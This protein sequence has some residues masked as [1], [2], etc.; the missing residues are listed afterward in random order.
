MSVVVK[1]DIRATVETAQVNIHAMTK[2]SD[3]FLVN[4]SL[5]RTIVV[6]LCMG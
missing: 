6:R 3:A 5:V 4:I 1:A 2:T